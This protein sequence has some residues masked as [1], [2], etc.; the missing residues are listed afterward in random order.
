MNLQK[1]LRY[2]AIA[3]LFLI[4]FFP[5]IVANPFF[6]PFITGKAFYFRILIEIGFA[7][8]IILAFLD[9]RYRPK[10]TRMTISV[11][12]FT[13]V[14]LL[15]DLLGVNVLRSIWS[16]FERMEGWLVVVHLWMFYVTATSMFTAKDQGKKL[17]HR[18]L[19]VSVVVALITAIYGLGQLI[20][21]FPTH[22]GSRV[23]A[24]LG[25]A[26]YM[27]VYMLM[28]TGI[29]AY[30]FFVARG[31]Q[32]VNS[33]ILQWVYPILS[34]IFGFLVIS[35]ATRGTTLGLIGG[36]MLAC[37][38]YAIFGKK[39]PTKWRWISTGVISLIILIGVVFWMNRDA[40]FIQ[41]NEVLSRMASISWSNTQGQA[42]QYIWPMA[43]SGALERPILGWG[44]ENFNYI[45]NK[46]YNP[47]MWNQ[48][49]WFD[50]AHSVFLD[51][52]VAAGFL[53][54][55]AYLALYVFAL[56]AIW[57]STLTI[58]EKSVLTGL[59]A[60]YAVHNI[61]VF[62]NLA[63]YVFFFAILGFAGSLTAKR[64]TK[65]HSKA[66]A[67][68]EKKEFSKDAVEYIVAPVAIV[69]LVAG[70][71]FLNIRP[72]QANVGL[73]SALRSCSG[74]TGAPPDPAP[75]NKVLGMNVY[76]ANQETR[77]QV[78]SCASGV[79]GSQLP[80]QIKQGFFELAQKAIND[81]IAAA[82]G[83]ARAYVLGGSFLAN[84][85]QME[86]AEKI[87]TTAHELTP[88][89]QGVSIQ[90][91]NVYVNKGENEKALALLKEAYESETSH[92]EARNAY[93]MGLIITGNEVE[94]KKLFGNMPEAFQTEQ[95]ARAY[96]V[97]KQ[98]TKAIDIYK[99]LIAI[100]AKNVQLRGNMA[101]V[102]YTA[103]MIWQATETLRQ[104]GVDFPEFKTQV[105]AAIKE[106]QAPK[107]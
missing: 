72:I 43:I 51:W 31:K 11:T 21:W 42:R 105:D 84:S 90:L 60:G 3:S 33:E 82:P 47:K 69:A 40:A 68:L 94:A 48:E 81:Q 64:H 39:E 103:G 53:G 98:Y 52:F 26:A 77:E 91:A 14:A 45:F 76:I 6:F 104:I 100:D 44:Q 28:H 30:L 36:I 66:S 32:I 73:I 24:S 57:R 65:K 12:L 9:A 88:K 19:N 27:A 49:Q 20:G 15:A 89:K 74:S 92:T 16:N 5:L 87:L 2:I 29:T 83:D 85:G 97:A 99:K 79:I 107:Q 58:A 38:L 101:Q 63:S 18:W 8:W 22:Q 106:I 46:D 37:A 34:V 17:W 86:E 10:L 95:V 75:F 25:N 50:R 41:R 78:L 102:Y 96:V 55:I 4:P 93:M 67:W 80:A 70:I 13:A 56:M 59:I 62:D 54:L 61:F 35:T 23:D 1:T 7:A 71:Y